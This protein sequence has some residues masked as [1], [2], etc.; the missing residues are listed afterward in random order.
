[1][2]AE[3]DVEL[4]KAAM[5]V[6]PLVT[7]QGVRTEEPVQLVLEELQAAALDPLQ[8]SVAAWAGAAKRETRAKA[9]IA[10]Q[11]RGKVVAKTSQ[12]S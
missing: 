6:G 4:L 1:M 7:S 3:A 10:P 12:S 9:T 2:A 8:V 11:P 5:S